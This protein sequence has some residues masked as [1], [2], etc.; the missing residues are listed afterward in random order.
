MPLPA[1][2]GF[3]SVFAGSTGS[4]GGGVTVGLD[5]L[6]IR[7]AVIAIHSFELLSPAPTGLFF[8]VLHRNPPANIVGDACP[9]R[10]ILIPHSGAGGM[11]LRRPFGSAFQF[12]KL[13]LNESDFVGV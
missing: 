9:N 12:C 8:S 7:G 6:P 3:A 11:C 1:P 5:F 2:F 13:A 4:T 10:A